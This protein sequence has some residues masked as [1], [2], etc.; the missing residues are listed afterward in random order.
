VLHVGLGKDDGS[1]ESGDLEDEDLELPEEEKDE[2]GVTRYYLFRRFEYK[3]TRLFL[4]KV[5]HNSF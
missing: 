2:E 4:F 5:A 1:S 3:E